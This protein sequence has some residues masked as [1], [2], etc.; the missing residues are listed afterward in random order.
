M[1]KTIF[2]LAATTTV[3]ALGLISSAKS[4]LAGQDLVFKLSNSS[5][6]AITEFY[7]SPSSLGHWEEDIL[8]RLDV[9][10][11]QSINININDGR[12]VCSYDLMM[13]FSDGDYIAEYDVD[14]CDLAGGIY[15]IT[16]D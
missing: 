4:T 15:T 1:N 12:D 16:E 6:Y 8:A 7:A 5:S 10:P 14:L 9:S 2:R 11:Y 13:V 3:V